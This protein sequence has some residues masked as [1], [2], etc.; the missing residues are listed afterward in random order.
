VAHETKEASYQR[1]NEWWQARK[2]ELDSQHP[3]AAQIQEQ[4][5]RLDWS[6]QHGR[7]DL[8]AQLENLIAQ[9][10]SD[11]GSNE[12]AT[13]PSLRL[14]VPTKEGEGPYRLSEIFVGDRKGVEDLASLIEQS[15]E[16]RVWEERLSTHPER[17]SLPQDRSVTSQVESWL[18]DL[19]A[20]VA[21]NQFGAGELRGQT[22]YIRHFV[23]FLGEQTPIDAISEE[24]WADYFRLLME[25]IGS[26]ECSPEYAK[27]LHRSARTFVEYLVS[28]KRI[29]PPGNL[30]DKRMKFS[31]P[32]REIELF[33]GPEISR[34]LNQSRDTIRLMILLAL[35]TGMTQ[36]DI[37]DLH[38]DE[39][40][41]EGGR[42]SR[43]RSKTGDHASVPT[44]EYRL[45]PE[46][47]DLLTRLRSSDP[48][49]VL[50]TKSGKP[51]V[52]RRKTN[53]DSVRIEF[54]KLNPTLSFKHLRKT[55]ASML[56]THPEYASYAQY[57]LSHAPNNVADSHYVKPSQER[58]DGAVTWLR[59][60]FL[61]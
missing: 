61:D 38:P 7:T 53:I 24:R 14:T 25:R 12:P 27:K 2:L 8:I 26:G 39:I 56:A 32:K 44:V 43:K 51:W 46:T 16:E 41:W 36:I 4:R 28:L 11:T 60:Q 17:P 57:F 15:Q 29:A 18:R 19:K 13:V 37:A 47:F 42:L 6:Q 48:T 35:N 49:R 55:A 45:W 21:A 10:K 5:R 23:A 52:D 31:V 50:V 3:N 20:R 58:F 1:A 9:L 22:S 34:L 30:N 40:D 33:S 59:D 54:E